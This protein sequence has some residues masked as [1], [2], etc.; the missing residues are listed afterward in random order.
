MIDLPS[1]GN[2]KRSHNT[3]CK[4]FNQLVLDYNAGKK[5]VSDIANFVIL[6]REET[7]IARMALKSSLAQRDNHTSTL[8][9]NVIQNAE[10]YLENQEKIS[11]INLVEVYKLA[12]PFTHHDA[13]WI[14]NRIVKNPKDIYN[15]LTNKVADYD[16]KKL[17]EDTDTVMKSLAEFAVSTM[18]LDNIDDFKV[19][20]NGKR[21]LHIEKED[22]PGV[23]IF[24]KFYS[25]V[26]ATNQISNWFYSQVYKTD[27]KKENW[28]MDE[29]TLRI[30]LHP[31]KEFWFQ[32][33]GDLFKQIASNP[34]VQETGFGSK[35]ID[36]FRNYNLEECLNQDDRCI[37][38]I[39]KESEEE[40][41]NIVLKYYNDFP[42]RF[43]PTQT[44][45]Q[46]VPGTE[47]ISISSDPKDTSFNDLHAQIIQSLLED[48]ALVHN[49]GKPR[50]LLKKLT[51]SQSLQNLFKN[52]LIQNYPKKQESFSLS[53]KNIA[54]I[55]S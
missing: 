24:V 26:L 34:Q 25:Q 36:F 39:P 50:E 49:L 10:Q 30:Y 44:L 33:Y 13:E 31:K 11:Q 28:T 42:D 18:N 43:E 17:K 37:F 41:Y 21:T 19:K 5:N 14:I 29:T 6:A 53:S 51:D 1:D 40:V 15:A 45:A 54:F 52:Y 35:T 27:E 16:P 55:R 22:D 32:V 48:F 9:L 47:G 46:A 20:Y 38:Y 8:L 23:G 12:K 4:Q 7:Q 2:I 3:V